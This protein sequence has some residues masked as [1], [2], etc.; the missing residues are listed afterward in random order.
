MIP[1]IK[2]HCLISFSCTRARLL[3]V[4]QHY[5]SYSR[6][7]AAYL[8]IFLIFW[9]FGTHFYSLNSS[10]TKNRFSCIALEGGWK[11]DAYSGIPRKY[12]KSLRFVVNLVFHHLWMCVDFLSA[13]FTVWFVGLNYTIFSGRQAQKCCCCWNY[14]SGWEQESTGSMVRQNDCT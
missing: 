4:C 1:I 5:P 13:F 12:S 6:W 7:R 11:R 14:H 2:S 9:N 10:R 3:C 8:I